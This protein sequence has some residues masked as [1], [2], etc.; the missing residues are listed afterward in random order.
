MANALQFNGS[1]TNYVLAT[2]PQLPQGS[3]HRTIEVRFKPNTGNRFYLSYGASATNQAFAMGIKGSGLNWVGFVNIDY[4]GNT[5][6]LSPI[7]DTYRD[8]ETDRKSTRLNSSHSAKS[9]MPSSA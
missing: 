6:L 9:R 1:N 8:W 2:I 4:Y 3:S 5:N 7:K